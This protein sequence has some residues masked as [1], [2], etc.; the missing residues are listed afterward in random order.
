MKPLSKKEFTIVGT[1]WY[2]RMC[3]EAKLFLLGFFKP[4]KKLYFGVRFQ[5]LLLKTFLVLTFFVLV[6]GCTKNSLLWQGAFVEGFKSSRLFFQRRRLCLLNSLYTVH[7]AKTHISQVL[8]YHRK[9]K[10]TM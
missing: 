6:T 1:S 2:N 5:K 10:K 8:E 7:C 4:E 3:Y 9:L